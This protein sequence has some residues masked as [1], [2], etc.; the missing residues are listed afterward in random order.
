MNV[1]ATNKDNTANVERMMGKAICAYANYVTAQ[2][3]GV[4]MVEAAIEANEN[5]KLN[6][7]YAQ[8]LECEHRA[9][10][11]YEATVRCIDMFVD[12]PLFKVCSIVISRCKEELGV[13]LDM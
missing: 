8:N 5:V 7:V 12:E 3:R 11:E 13:S 9:V 1:T 4:E 2:K 10:S 6:G